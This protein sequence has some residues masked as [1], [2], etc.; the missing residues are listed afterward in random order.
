MAT[1]T[2]NFGWSVPTSTDLVTNGAV[3]IETLGDAV[4]ASVWNLTNNRVTVTTDAKSTGRVGSSADTTEGFYFST[5]LSSLVKDANAVL[6]LNRTTGTTSASMISFLRNGTAAGTINAST[7]AAP[8]LVAPSDY[9]LKENLE[10][11]TDAADRIKSANV[12]TYNFISD[13]DKELRY[14]F[15]AHEVADLMHDLVIGEKDAV[16]EDGQPV[17]QQVQETRLIPVLVAAL[18]DA[19]LRIDALEAAA[20]PAVTATRAKK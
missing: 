8:T 10:P 18:K 1:T 3:A 7:T 12:Y 16:D 9:R 13:E 15:L 5:S 2:P 6:N 20:A 11:L 14:G 4:D 17:Y 19:L